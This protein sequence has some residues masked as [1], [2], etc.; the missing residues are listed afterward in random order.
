MD[1]NLKGYSLEEYFCQVSFTQLFF[2]AL[3]AAKA[4]A[5]HLA[6]LPAA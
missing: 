2:Q 3:Q 5:N 1:K 4:E 6:L